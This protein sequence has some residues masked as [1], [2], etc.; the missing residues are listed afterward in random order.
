MSAVQKEETEKKRGNP[1]WGKGQS[2]NP[3]GRPKI[4]DKDK[5]TNKELRSDEFMSLVRKF[6]PH[7]SKAV[8]AAVDILENKEA[9]ESGKLRASALIIQTY[10]DLVKE[11][12]DFRYDEDEGEEIQEQNKMATFSLRMIGKED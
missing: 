11:L 7:L 8:K 2:G 10:K 1:N 4:L 9:S 3:E 5:K 6:K 12:Y